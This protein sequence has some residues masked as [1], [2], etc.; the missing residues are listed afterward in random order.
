MII[1]NEIVDICFLIDILVVFRTTYIDTKIGEEVVNSKQ[2]AM[3]YLKKQ[4]WIDFLAM[5][6][7]DLITSVI[8]F[9]IIFKDVS[10]KKFV[11]ELLTLGSTKTYQSFQA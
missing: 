10:F 4:F 6:P 8:T 9:N 3:M 2:I 5:I 1:I 11:E 7:L